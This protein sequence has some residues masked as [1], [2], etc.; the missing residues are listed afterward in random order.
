[1]DFVPLIDAIG[2]PATLALVG[3]LLGLVFG[4]AAQ[5][6]AFCTRSAVIALADARSAPAIA[7]WLTGFAVAL[8]ATQ[9]LAA[10]GLVDLSA[11]R[12]F[13]VPQNL[14]AAIVGGALFG[15]GMV[16][17]R[18]C[19]SR[20]MV[21][22]ASGN[23]RALVAVMLIAV[24]AWATIAGPLAPARSALAAGLPALFLADNAVSIGNTGTPV[25]GLVLAAM[26]V[27]AAFWMA[28]RHEHPIR[29]AVWPALIGLT[30]A[31]GWYATH[32]LSGQLFDPIVTES[33]TYLRPTATSAQFLASAVDPQYLGLD[34]GIVAGTLA[35]AFIAATMS[36]SFRFAGFGEAGAAHPLR[37]VSGAVLMG[38][39][40]VL[41]GGCTIG[42]GLSGGSA[43]AIS[44]L[45]A[46]AAMALSAAGTHKL[47]EA[48]ATR[49]AP[50][51]PGVTLP[52]E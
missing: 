11:N 14:S 8:A 43:L 41:A 29:L 17:A 39:G 49:N 38:F 22:A 30:I 37:Y 36:G 24:T 7:V 42:A 13:D 26:L 2:E 32:T 44:A 16:L 12:F 31:G 34:T 20:L 47:L 4:I 10:A 21:L 35:G 46:L 50:T 33:L 19:A 52:A 3:G 25:I 28:A 9:G 51:V 5:R 48:L 15:I 45:A 1:M 6:S 27:V 18:G 23:G 40:G